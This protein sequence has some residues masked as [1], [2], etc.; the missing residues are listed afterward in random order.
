[1]SLNKL[2]L[3]VGGNWLLS[4]VFASGLNNGLQKNEA[5]L[6]VHVPRIIN[7]LLFLFLHKTKISLILLIIQSCN[8]LG[9]SVLLI[10]QFILDL[11]TCAPIWYYISC[12]Y[13][14]IGVG[15]IIV[16][17]SQNPD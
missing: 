7:F 1:M 16:D 12:V 11:N 8:L 10:T 5:S 2:W 17:L 15:L 4:L 3:V 13:S 14:V 9:I 6:S